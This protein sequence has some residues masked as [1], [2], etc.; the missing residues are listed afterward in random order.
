MLEYFDAPAF[1]MFT[2]LFFGQNNLARLH[3]T[4]IAAMVVLNLKIV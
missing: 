1:L 4:K 3:P 2:V